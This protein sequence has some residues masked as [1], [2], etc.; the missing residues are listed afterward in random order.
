MTI[1][2]VGGIT[3]G[4]LV[5][6][7]RPAYSRLM[8][9][10]RVAFNANEIARVEGSIGDALLS[11][12]PTNEILTFI[13]KKFPDIHIGTNGILDFYRNEVRWIVKDQGEF[14]WVGVYSSG[15][16]GI[17]ETRD[18]LRREGGYYKTSEDE[19]PNSPAGRD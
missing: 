2:L 4:A 5:L 17:W 8:T 14:F 15:E 1:L 16:D 12:C 6:A 3:L 11:G 7:L 18:D 10:V 9:E 13:G 19:T